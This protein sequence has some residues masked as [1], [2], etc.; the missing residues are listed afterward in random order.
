LRQCNR[1]IHTVHEP[2]QGVMAV[3]LCVRGGFAGWR[4]NCESAAS[5][6]GPKGSHLSV[7]GV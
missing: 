1:L 6:G 4:M 7:R 2:E 5:R 3:P